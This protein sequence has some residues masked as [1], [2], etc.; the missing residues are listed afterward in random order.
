MRAHAIVVGGSIGGLLVARVLSE[1]FGHVTVVERDVLPVD[2]TLRPGVPQARH[3]HA[4]LSRGLRIFD[5]LLPGLSAELR[6]RGA[7]VVEHGLDFRTLYPS[8][9]HPIGAT[10]LVLCPSSRGLLEQAIR[11]RVRAIGNVTLLAPCT[12]RGLVAAEGRVVGLRVDRAGSGV[13]DLGADLVV[14]ASGRSSRS[15]EW[16]DALGYGRP[17]ERVIDAAWGYATRVYARPDGAP[18]D[19]RGVLSLSRPPDERRTGVLQPIEGERWLVTLAGVLG[20]HPPIDEDGFLEF[21]RGLRTPLI[22]DAMRS[23]RPLTPIHGY[24]HTAN[25][26]RHYERMRPWPENFVVAGDALCAFN[27]VYG[28]GMTVCGLEALEIAAALDAAPAPS[29]GFSSRLQRRLARVVDGPWLMATGEDLRWVGTVGTRAGR[30]TRLLHWYLDRVIARIPS[31]PEVFR[32]FAEVGHLVRPPSALFRPGLM[33]RVLLPRGRCP[34][35]G[36]ARQRSTDVQSSSDA[37]LLTVR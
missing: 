4:L 10:G 6:R 3:L 17:E 18:T 22:H 32:A 36:S 20:E 34:S 30:V 1:R 19:W 31:D 24:R 11:E 25:R 14:D 28:Q 5:E 23:A 29:P 26:R 21:A 33:A 9:W 13:R 7:P 37:R 27:P 16:L 8:G 12:A 15:P 35:A 2:G